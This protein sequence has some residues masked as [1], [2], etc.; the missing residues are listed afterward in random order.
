M[1]ENRRLKMIYLTFDTN[2]WIYSLDESW[3]IEN[4]LDYLEP[5]IENS[6]V[7]ILLPQMIINE[8]ANHEKRQTEE[9]E[10]KLKTFFEMAEEILPSAFF[11]EYKEPANQRNIIQNQLQRAKNVIDKAEIIPDYVEVKQQ[12]IE[13]GISKKAPM[14][15]KSSI[16]DA[17]IVY[18]LIHFAKLNPGNHYY[19]ISKN[20]EDFYEAEGKKKVI[21]TD[22]KPD[23]D[24]YNIKAYQTLNELTNHLRVFH[25]L[26]N[27]ENLKQKRRDRLK[28]KLSEKIYNPEYEKAT[29]DIESGFIQNLN[30]IDFI[31]KENKP[32]K[33]QVIFVL[34]LIDTDSNY[35]REFYN[36]IIKNVVWFKILK[37]KGVFKPKNF[38]NDSQ[39]WQPLIF[40]NKVS[41]NIKDGEDLE[42]IDD[43]INIIFSFSKDSSCNYSTWHSFMDILGN[44]PNSN[45]SIELLNYIPAWLETD[46]TNRILS[47]PL[48][49]GLLPKFLPLN[50]TSNDI[51][52][53][54]IILEHLFTIQKVEPMVQNKETFGEK[55]YFSRISMNQLNDAFGNTNSNR[56]IGSVITHCSDSV[57][58]QLADNL[59][60]IRFD[61][62]QGINLNF[63]SNETEYHVRVIIEDKNLNIFASE[64]DSTN[65]KSLIIQDFEDYSEAETKRMLI[66]KLQEININIGGDELEIVIHGL[67]NGSHY[68]FLEKSISKL[69]EHYYHDENLIEVFTL[70]F[71]NILNE[72]AKSKHSDT[73]KILRTFITESA[74]RLPIFKRIILFV[75]SENWNFTKEI[76]WEMLNDNDKDG[77]FTKYEYRKDLYE[78][79]NK[80]QFNLTKDEIEILQ[81]IIDNSSQETKELIDEDI[82]YWKHRWYSALRGIN[83]FKTLYNKISN[84]LNLTNEH[85]ESIGEFRYRVGSLS[86]FSEEEILQKSNQEIVEYIYNFNPKDK[87]E[88]PSIDGLAGILK[89]S[90]EKEPQ[91]FSDEI[92]LYNEISY[93]YINEMLRGFE[94][95]WKN[96]KKFDWQK[97]LTFCKFYIENEEFYTEKR[98]L[99]ADDSRATF[100]WVVGAIGN[101][102]TEGCRSDT[103]AFDLELLPIA[104]EILIILVSNL[105]SIDNFKQTNMDY[106]TYSLNS[107]A[108]KTLRALFD[109]SLRLARTL[110]NNENESKWEY[111]I[112]ILY[113][114]TLT[115][116]FIDG[117]IFIGWYFQQFYFL[118]KDWIIEKVKEFYNLEEKE[119]LAFMGG[120]AFGSPPF[121]K[122]IYQI[123]YPH[124]LR[125]IINKIQ[126]KG[127]QGNGLITHLGTF[128]LW[129]FE[130]LK[131][132]G[133][134]T[135]LLNKGE[136]KSIQD[137]INYIGWQND[138]YKSLGEEETIKFQKLIYNLWNKVVS[139][140]QDS[141]VQEGK[142]II[143]LLLTFLEFIP[144]LNEE[145]TQLALK[146]SKFLTLDN[147]RSHDVIGNLVILKDKGNSLETAKNLGK[148][149][150]S[151]PFTQY[152]L[153]YD[154]DSLTNIV[155]FLYEN[156]QK[157]IADE[158]CN[159]VASL[160]ADFLIEI[161]KKYNSQ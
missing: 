151:I 40:L 69:K 159:K 132:E 139:K 18:S 112:K 25:N 128:Y 10:K 56:L 22:L 122:E 13:K 28:N 15:N 23:F 113:E 9:R 84:S 104:K 1:F 148:I 134:L 73:I 119:W 24:S 106:P 19:F 136:L 3:T 161:Y 21:H 121:N 98:I 87:W 75:I 96:G 48:C 131:H 50:P 64:E 38:P 143:L 137:F 103:N 65:S 111:D 14:H 124:Y 16:A 144:E 57:I 44:L 55:S 11:A 61:F 59:K 42:L 2:I 37:Q 20:T 102:I 115:N 82:D 47:Y 31:L 80:H 94:E 8:W 158:F 88:E 33:E 92:E 117:Y 127:I 142:D 30:T 27:D 4:Q 58:F 32:T 116:G 17:L 51:A 110:K 105:K 79:L 97:V 43:L 101:L 12:I 67:I 99:Q 60:K 125:A 78:L 7:K 89:K 62:P 70:I 150:A 76:L 72:K 5:W 95:A 39:F 156:K 29:A 71:R 100:E 108:G 90:V 118:D 109:Y 155:I 54:E 85:H 154:I 149:L 63:E 147:L 46:T 93:V 77:Y 41:H 74:Y 107:T 36:R 66:E 86:P 45:I 126:L 68:E 157:V 6:E 152:H 135:T 26:K 123:F 160:G 34:A 138:Y 81:R 153:R 145:Y 130:D 49:D 114:E 146:S 133:L 140:F 52:K 91:R 141:N 120:F 83:P 35:E 129:G 53:A